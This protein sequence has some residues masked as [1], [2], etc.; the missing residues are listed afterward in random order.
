MKSIKNIKNNNKGFTL[1]E[2]LAVIVILAILVMIAIPAVTKYL[3]ASRQGAF[4]DNAH[5]AIDAVRTDV[6]SNG[7]TN[8]NKNGS[9]SGSS[10]TY[11]QTQINKL[12]DKGLEQSPFG[13]GYKCISITV[14]QTASG[15]SNSDSSFSY[16]MTMI[17]NANNGFASKPEKEINS[18]AVELAQT[19]LS[20]P[21]QTS[22]Q[23]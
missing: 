7:F 17:D 6:I 5:R 4:A 3:T 20:C 23:G 12:L 22:Q 2:L 15:D 19:S 11:N 9:C 21:Q 8:S 14:T 16:N 10:C 18:T 13:G 1:I